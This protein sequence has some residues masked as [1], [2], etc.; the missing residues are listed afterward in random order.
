VG[1]QFLVLFFQIL[2]QMCILHFDKI[3]LKGGSLLIGIH[4]FKS[5][6]RVGHDIVYEGGALMPPLRGFKDRKTLYEIKKKNISF[7]KK[8]KKF[9]TL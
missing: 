9:S 2:D 4:K 8:T 5:R 7:F 1:K 6:G 3:K